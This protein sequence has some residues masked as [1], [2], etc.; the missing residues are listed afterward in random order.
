MPCLVTGGVTRFA[1]LKTVKRPHRKGNSVLGDLIMSLRK[2][3]DR[4]CL[5]AGHKSMDTV[6]WFTLF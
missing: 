1:E 5:I 2:N 4:T 6:A 3:F